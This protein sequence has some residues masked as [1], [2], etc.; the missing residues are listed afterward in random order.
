MVLTITKTHTRIADLLHLSLSQAVYMPGDADGDSGSVSSVLL[1]SL[2][3]HIQSSLGVSAHADDGEEDGGTEGKGQGILS[4]LGL[5]QMVMREVERAMQEVVKKA[6][7]IIHPA[8]DQV[9]A[10]M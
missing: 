8:A 6:L 2:P 9:G 7:T 1:K 5:E 10:I 3:V 4:K